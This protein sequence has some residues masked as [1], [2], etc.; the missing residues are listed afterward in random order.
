MAAILAP[1]EVEEEIEHAVFGKRSEVRRGRDRRAIDLHQEMQR[2]AGR[3]SWPLEAGSRDRG[4]A[5]EAED[6]V[7]MGRRKQLPEQDRLPARR[8]DQ[9]IALFSAAAGCRDGDGSSC[10]N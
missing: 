9:F 3:G 10:R 4:A 2:L 5:P 8:L 6:A 7:V 1:F